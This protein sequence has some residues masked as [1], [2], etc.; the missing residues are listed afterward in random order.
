VSASSGSDPVARVLVYGRSGCHLCDVALE[1]VEEV[2]EE[3]GERFAEVDID[4]SEDLV[5][6][7]ND[8]VPVVL[9]DGVEIA[10]WRVDAGTLRAA[11]LG[12]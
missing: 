3:T 10:T 2:C 11:L 1:V 4:S 9:V 6:R 12:G 7:Y 8:L 5:A